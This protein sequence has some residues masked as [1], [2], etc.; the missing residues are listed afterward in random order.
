MSPNHELQV[1][2]EEHSVPLI[3]HPALP[4]PT[5]ERIKTWFAQNR[6]LLSPAL[7]ATSFV[8]LCALIGSV[9]LATLGRVEEYG[10]ATIETAFDSRRLQIK[11]LLGYQLPLSILTGLV[12]MA[13]DYVQFRLR[14][15]LLW[16][17]LMLSSLP[18][19]LFGNSVFFLA[20]PAHD[21]YEIL[22]SESFFTGEPFNLSQLHMTEFRDQVAAPQ[23]FGTPWPSGWPG[24][25]DLQEMLHIVQNDPSRWNNISN[26]DCRTRYGS[27][28]Y[29]DFRSVLLVTN[30]PRVSPANNSALA[31]GAL[32]GYITGGLVTRFMALCP[33][34]Y[35]SST[36]A[37]FTPDS[38]PYL[39]VA[40]LHDEC[41]KS[42]H[43][44]GIP[45]ENRKV[46]K[47]MSRDLCYSYVNE[48]RTWNQ[49]QELTLS[50]CLS[51]PS[52]QLPSLIVYNQAVVVVL[53]VATAIKGFVMAIACWIYRGFHQEHERHSKEKRMDLFT[54]LPWIIYHALVVPEFIM[55][56]VIYYKGLEA[57]GE[58]ISLPRASGGQWIFGIA[59]Y[60][61]M[62]QVV[63]R[64]Q[65]VCVSIWMTFRPAQPQIITILVG[66]VS[67]FYH[68]A[69]QL[70]A[71]GFIN[72]LMIQR[73]PLSASQEADTYQP[74]A[75]LDTL[76]DFAASMRPMGRSK[77][78]YWWAVLIAALGYRH[79]IML[80]L[81]AVCG[82]VGR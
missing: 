43:A 39:G 63:Y 55:W 76:Y 73:Y 58:G 67:F 26:P 33:E 40:D 23:P 30:W 49:S 81:H 35:L 27:Q 5:T 24:A 54:S 80:L 11:I 42:S 28:L 70:I 2:G 61:N 46:A 9:L 4:K 1:L 10:I 25:A 29:S 48:N 74:I 14:S 44:S 52:L 82:R 38:T 12:A 16:I 21:A 3:S 6:S 68:L 13:S 22:V 79:M 41:F 57:F 19:P 78:W 65:Q 8:L 56:L 71:A 59:A 51:E 62:L 45:C 34:A 64:F 69:I 77:Y 53:L 15:G 60:V 7:F 20:R 37:S 18:F 31:I 47:D 32:P 72:I 36:P 50:Y 66:I 17:I 75:L